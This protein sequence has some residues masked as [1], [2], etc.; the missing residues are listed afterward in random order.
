VLIDL[1]TPLILRSWRDC[2]APAVLAAFAAADM[3]Q[4]AGEPITDLAAARRWLA[5]ASAR[6][7]RERGFV[8]AVTL[9]DDVPVGCIAITDIDRHDCGWVSYWTAATVRGSG[10]AGDALSALTAWVHQVH[11]VSRLELGHRV[12]NPAS[13]R[14]AVK[15]GFTVEGVERG[16]LC[17]GGER[18]DVARYA[19]LAWD[20]CPQPGRK[21]VI[22]DGQGGYF[23]SA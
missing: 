1:D 11:R 19:R 23:E 3:A 5:W 18:F 10:V 17:Y 20:P 6:T 2:D 7:S 14:V 9:P 12:N 15:A 8:F 13:G 16:K 4:Q 22:D 21:V